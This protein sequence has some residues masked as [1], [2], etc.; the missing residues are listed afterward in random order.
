MDELLC[1]LSQKPSS[2]II[3]CNEHPCASSW[4]V[5]DWGPCSVSCG[6]G[7]KLRDVYCTENVNST[8]IKVKLLASGPEQPHI[9]IINEAH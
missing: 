2:K 6:D 8:K 5:E 3:E 7:L 4:A 9:I 1:N